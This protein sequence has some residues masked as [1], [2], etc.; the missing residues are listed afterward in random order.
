MI[1]M[2]FQRREIDRPCARFQNPPMPRCHVTLFHRSFA[3][4][5]I[6]QAFDG[7]NGDVDSLG[8]ISMLFPVIRRNGC[9][10]PG[11]VISIKDYEKQG[12]NYQT[13]RGHGYAMFEK[14]E[15]SDPV[16]G[17]FRYTCCYDICRGPDYGAVPSEACTKREGPPE[18]A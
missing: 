15:E 17:L 14:F 7:R 3:R 6:V 12:S 16:T 5:G 8:Q 10:T 13:D 1:S 18:D 2:L 9:D 11:F 4:I